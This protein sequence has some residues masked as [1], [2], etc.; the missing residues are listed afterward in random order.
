MMNKKVII[1]LIWCSALLAGLSYAQPQKPVASGAQTEVTR[2]RESKSEE[3]RDELS[4]KL[5]QRKNELRKE[6][7]E[8]NKE[9]RNSEAK[10]KSNNPK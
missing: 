7:H 6:E 5:M 3:K 8:H 10:E 9:H 2:T 4:K 1:L